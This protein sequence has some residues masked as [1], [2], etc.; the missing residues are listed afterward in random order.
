MNPVQTILPAARA[1]DTDLRDA[2]VSGPE[3]AHLAATYCDSPRALVFR[4]PSPDWRLMMLILPLASRLSLL[5]NP[6]FAGLARTWGLGVRFIGI[7][8]NGMA[9][10][11]R[12]LLSDRTLRLLIELLAECERG[13][14]RNEAPWLDVLFE[15]LASEMLTTLERRRDDWARHLD[16]QHRLEPGSTTSLFVH[17]D[18]YPDFA[19]RLRQAL[20][21]HS[22]DIGFYGRVLR[23]IDEREAEVDLR[24]QNVVL[25]QLDALSLDAMQGSGVGLHLGGYNWLQIAPRHRP[26][27]AHLLSRLPWMAHF[28]AETLI[29]VDTG[30][31]IDPRDRVVRQAID[32]G[33]DRLAIEALAE[34][35][36]VSPALVRRLWR[37]PP[38]KLGTPPAWLLPGL[39]RRLET[40]TDHRWPQREEE[41]LT[42]IEEASEA[43]LAGR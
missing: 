11:F 24:M 15:A 35:L 5:S 3:L 27:R 2:G 34:R 9:Y 26:A 25:G 28:L 41:W 21:E 19:A 16:R 38:R 40:M 1:V 20:R 8:R 31:I 18:R 14:L 32:A 4:T 42:L 37:E 22:I 36:E 23:S 12:A 13:T 10:D 39:M 17:E 30:G 7:D 33:Q 43:V 6:I 29:N